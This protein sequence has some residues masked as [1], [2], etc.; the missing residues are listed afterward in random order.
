MWI[1]CNERMPEDMD[2]VIALYLGSWPSRG[3]SG[4]IDIYAVRGKWFNIPEGVHIVGWMA[5]PDTAHLPIAE[6]CTNQ[7]SE[8]GRLLGCIE[9][10]DPVIYEC[11][12]EGEALQVNY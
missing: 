11:I 10:S 6:H 8:P 2:T 4:V 5:V 9:T 7:S 1:N 3:N 12:F